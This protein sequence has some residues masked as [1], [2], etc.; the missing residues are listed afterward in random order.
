MKYVESQHTPSLTIYL[1][2]RDQTLGETSL[3]KLRN[4]LESQ[5]ILSDNGG[6]VDLK[7]KRIDL[8]DEQTMANAKEDLL[9]NHG[10]VLK[11]RQNTN[12][13]AY[14]SLRNLMSNKLVSRFGCP[15]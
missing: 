14:Y 5:K 3:A 6:N 15:G 8:T 7:F 12:V 13:Q 4:E 11:K 1:S 9:K 10:G 2:A